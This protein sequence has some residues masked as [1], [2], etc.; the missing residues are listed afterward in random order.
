MP[1]FFPWQVWYLYR[2]MNLTFDDTG[3]AFVTKTD[4]DL[5]RAHLLF[6]TLAHPWMVKWFTFK[7]RIAL[8]LHL[9]VS[10]IL[11]PT[12][13]RHFCGGETLESCLPRVKQMAACG[14]SS[15]LDYSVEGSEKPDGID[16]SL[17][18]TLRSIRFAAGNPNIPFAV[19]KP[20]AFVTKNLLEKAS[21]SETLSLTETEELNSFRRRI[22]TLCQA[23]YNLQIPILIDAEDSWYQSLIDELV[24]AMM[25]RFNREQAIIFNTFQMYRRDRFD[26]L[27]ASFAK[28]EKGNYF[29]GAKFV[30][31]AYMEKER[32]R[33]KKMGYPSAIQPD[34]EN[35]DRDY[36]AALKFSA[37]HIDRISIFNGTHNEISSIY[38]AGLMDRH[39]IARNDPR[40]WFSQLYGMSDHISFNLAHHGFN[41][42][43]YLPYG[44]LKHVVPYL[45]RRAEENTSVAGQ[46]SRELTLIELERNR[47][48]IQKH[49]P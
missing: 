47:R 22:L 37:E 7:I 6:S 13:Y 18:E 34:K 23:A 5:R 28:A 33:A 19:F 15:I 32:E 4:P 29:L 36:N 40:I 30:R 43:K 17:E 45:L 44:P 46:T 1:S 2:N 8:K 11:K 21:S 49:I 39:G 3:I 41:V 12:I 42:A 26:F 10:W 20:T 48:K 25:E 38:L 27:K 24:A 16:A 35:T 14:V 9:P 31:G